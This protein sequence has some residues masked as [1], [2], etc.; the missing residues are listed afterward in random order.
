MMVLLLLEQDGRKLVNS[1]HYLGFAIQ[2]VTNNVL[3]ISS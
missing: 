3:E 2:N 1:S